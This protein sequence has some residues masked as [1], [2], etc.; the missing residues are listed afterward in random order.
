[1]FSFPRHSEA[2]V[3]AKRSFLFPI[4]KGRSSI[5]L[6]IVLALLLSLS[7]FQAPSFL[8]ISEAPARVDAVVIFVGGEKGAREKEADQLVREGFADYLL[9]PGYGQ[10]MKRGPEGGLAR[11]DPG[12]SL[13]TLNFKLKTAA[14]ME[15]T[16][17]EVLGAKRLMDDLGLRSALFVSS[18]YHMRRIKLISGKVFNDRQE[19]RYVPT[20]YETPVGTYWLFSNRE[21][22]FV[23]TEYAKIV[24][25]FLYSSFL[26]DTTWQEEAI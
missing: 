10:I 1:L 26:S 4:P 19:V 9:I 23:L 13:K 25:F 22:A 20:R 16:H 6:Y 14:R 17:I 7:I 8:L 21:R 5:C 12:S 24:W 2:V 3:P 15:D 11:L 18:P